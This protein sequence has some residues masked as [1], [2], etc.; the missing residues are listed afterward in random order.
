MSTQ[1]EDQDQLGGRVPRRTQRPRALSRFTLPLN[2]RDMTTTY[3]TI[4]DRSPPGL[5]GTAP[6]AVPQDG[7]VQHAS[8]ASFTI[9][10]RDNITIGTWNT[11]TLRARGKLQE[12]T[13]EMDRYRWNILGLSNEMEELLRY[14]V[15]VVIVVVVAVCEWVCVW[16]RGCLY[17]CGCLDLVPSISLVPVSM[18]FVGF[19]NDLLCLQ[20]DS[21]LGQSVKWGLEVG[22]LFQ[23]LALL[24]WCR[25]SCICWCTLWPVLSGIWL[26]GCLASDMLALG[27]QPAPYRERWLCYYLC[28]KIF[29]FSLVPKERLLSRRWRRSVICNPSHLSGMRCLS[30][31]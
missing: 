4:A 1:L 15:V 26:R 22:V 11:R 28:L 30:R 18:L 25:H 27:G 3:Q 29:P 6:S 5:I 31:S 24:G 17:V 9:R 16:V 20:I 12:L 23:R 19:L 7:G 10:G 8:D 14:V 21:M 13:H 2:H